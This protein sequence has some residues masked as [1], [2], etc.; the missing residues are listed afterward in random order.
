MIRR[1]SITILLLVFPITVCGSTRLTSQ[2]T[3]PASNF[4]RLLQGKNYLELEEALKKSQHISASER[5]F[6]TGVLANRQNHITISLRLLEP[7]LTDPGLR[8]TPKLEKFGLE[9][10]ADDYV[11]SFRY[12]D[13]ADTYTRLLH[14]LGPSLSE[15]DKKD[16]QGTLNTF[17]L[18]RRVP[19]QTI[20][21]EGQFTVPTKRN[22]VDLIEAPVVVG[23][24][25]GY[26]ILDT[27]ANISLLTRTKA[28]QIGLVLSSGTTP[29]MV[30]GGRRVQVHTSVIPVLRIGQAEVRNVAVL[31]VE[32]K[33]YFIP[34]MNFQV[35]ALLGYPVLSAL[36]RITFYS[37]G[38]FGA[39]GKSVA[40]SDT[41]AEIFME[42]LTPLVAAGVG[43]DLRLFAFDSGA[44][45]SYFTARY[46]R[47][48]KRDFANQKLGRVELAGH[49][50]PLPS[51]TAKT[52]TLTFGGVPLTLNDVSVLSQPGGNGLDYFYGN[53]GQDIVKSLRSYTLDFRTMRF[54]VEL[55]ASKQ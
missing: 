20:K 55:P 54:S 4:G 11:K 6:F 31:V 23:G 29:M 51:Y 43:K 28:Q 7:I 8:F 45:D 44:S 30:F 9:T 3:D 42:L 40:Q 39:D 5:D 33:D 19:V 25:T 13:A 46:Q 37:D 48:Y 47:T 53:L 24:T 2:A 14:R 10:L 21:M 49:P 17:E 16:I 22:A 41:G 52:V 36:G 12:A 34:Q 18:L 1:L 26:W 50:H 15:G 38:H 35:D 32:D 27:G